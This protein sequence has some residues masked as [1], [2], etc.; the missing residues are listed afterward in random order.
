MKITK[1]LLALLLSL[2]LLFCFAA[3]GEKE[4]ASS[5]TNSATSTVSTGS[6]ESSPEVNTVEKKGV[7]VDATYLSDTTL[8]EG[9]KTVK[10]EISAEKQ[11]I[12][13]TVKTNAATVGEALLNVG[14]VEGED[15]QYGLFIK[16]V[17]GITA[18][19]DV[20]KAYWAF[21]VNGAYASAG[22]DQTEIDEKVTYKLE[23]TK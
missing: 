21:Y 6:D 15:S 3:C 7:W 23:Y 18:D 1:K 19:Y 17:N 5:E 13:L 22:V 12:T 20:N 9:A 4:D 10:V 11:V 16:K 8:G 2:A 14:V